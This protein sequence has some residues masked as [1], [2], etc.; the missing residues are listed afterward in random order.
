VALIEQRVPA[1]IEKVLLD[2]S[3]HMVTVDQQRE[4]VIERS[5]RFFERIAAAGAVPE[6]VTQAA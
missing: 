5:A 1:P 4:I 6:R 2:D 3:Y